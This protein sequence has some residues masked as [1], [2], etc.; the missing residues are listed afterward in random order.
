M[1]EAGLKNRL[2]HF[3]KESLKSAAGAV[4]PTF[5]TTKLVGSFASIAWNLVKITTGQKR[6]ILPLLGSAAKAGLFSFLKKKIP[7]ANG[8]KATIESTHG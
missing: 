6:A 4:V 3:P 1:M 5:L 7:A 8:T 2:V